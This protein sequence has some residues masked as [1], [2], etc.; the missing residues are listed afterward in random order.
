MPIRCKRLDAEPLDE[1]R[2]HLAHEGSEAR[3]SETVVERLVRDGDAVLVV[4]LTLQIRERL[5]SPT[6]E[7]LDELVATAASIVNRGS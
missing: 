5:D 3:P 6:R 2:E 4:E 1:P 7:L